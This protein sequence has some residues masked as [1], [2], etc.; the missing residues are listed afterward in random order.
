MTYAKVNPD[1]DD[2]DDDV[3]EWKYCTGSESQDGM[4]G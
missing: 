3:P 2:D 1:D 4:F